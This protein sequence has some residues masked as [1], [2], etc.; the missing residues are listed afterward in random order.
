M[1]NAQKEELQRIVKETGFLDE[2]KKQFDGS[3]ETLVDEKD[4]KL[5][6]SF[7]ARD[8]G[9]DIMTLG[10][11]AAM[12]QMERSALRLKTEARAQRTDP[13]PI[14]FFKI[15]RSIRFSRP[16]VLAWLDREKEASRNPVKPLPFGKQ[17]KVK[18][19]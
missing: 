14:P 15:G 1:N 6:I 11:L 9:N 12:L 10:D 16:E 18:I 13:N 17:K 3:Y 2:I 7:I 4:G 19:K 5:R 8:T